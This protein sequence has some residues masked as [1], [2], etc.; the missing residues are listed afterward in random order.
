MGKAGKTHFFSQ[1][2]VEMNAALQQMMQSGG[3]DPEVLQ[4]YKARVTWEF[5]SNHPIV[6]RYTM[7]EDCDRTRYIMEGDIAVPEW[8][9]VADSAKTILG[10]S[11]QQARTTL[12]GRQWTAWYAEDIPMSYG[13]WKLG[14]LPGLILEAYDETRIYIFTADGLEEAKGDE[15][16]RLENTSTLEKVTAKDLTRVREIANPKLYSGRQ[17]EDIP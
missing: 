8:E 2:M 10:Y 3:M 17:G 5:F 14:G 7:L 1:S 9:V 15:P 13:P 11:C 16:I 4:K 6:G 12:Y